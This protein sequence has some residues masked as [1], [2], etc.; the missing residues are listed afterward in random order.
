MLNLKKYFQ[1]SSELKKQI[2]IRPMNKI[3]INKKG[4][5]ILEMIPVIIVLMVLLRYTYGFFGIIQSATL[6]SIA[7]RNYS[8]ETFRH[9]SR[10][11]YLREGAIEARTEYK[12]GV[13][14]HGIRDESS[15]VTATP[16][17]DVARRDISFPPRKVDKIGSDS[18][19]ARSSEQYNIRVGRRYAD[20]DGVNQVWLAI[21]YGMCVDFRCGD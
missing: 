9:R 19:V 10:L 6:Q 21:R 13:R 14:L 3:L 8:Y 2:S 4:T 20:G 18:Y 16:D 1:K 5:A 15:N 17:W 12:K 7:A 11:G